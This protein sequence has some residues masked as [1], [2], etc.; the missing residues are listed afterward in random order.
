[1]PLDPQSFNNKLLG[2]NSPLGF[3]ELAIH[4]AQPLQIEAKPVYLFEQESL[5][6]CPY[7]WIE[8][9]SELIHQF[10]DV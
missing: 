6:G 1:M 4:Y 3:G 2:S 5:Q 9:P 7:G 10:F 8:L